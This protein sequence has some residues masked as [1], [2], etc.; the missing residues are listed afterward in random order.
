[1]TYGVSQGNIDPNPIGFWCLPMNNTH[2]SVG[3]RLLSSEGSTV[4]PV[5]HARC[6]K[7]WFYVRFGGDPRCHPSE[8]FE[9]VRCLTCLTRRFVPSR[10][11]LQ[12][13]LSSHPK[14]GAWARFDLTCVKVGN[15]GMRLPI[16][17]PWI[18]PSSFPT[19]R[20]SQSYDRD[21]AGAKRRLQVVGWTGPTSSFANR[22]TP[23]LLS[24]QTHS[25]NAFGIDR[26]KP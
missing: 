2:P 9:D 20:T 6:E 13:S 22:T 4:T 26:S 5:T 1:M 8:S 11:P 24:G 15:Q 23:D 21:M 10:V 14:L 16:E 17:I 7:R 25:G 18:Q 12:K 3:K 19:C